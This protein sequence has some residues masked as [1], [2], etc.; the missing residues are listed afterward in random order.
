MPMIRGSGR[1]R[2]ILTAAVVLSLVPQMAWAG[3]SRGS[4]GAAESPSATPSGGAGDDGSLYA[5]VVAYDESKNGSGGSAG[6]VAPAGDW[7][8]PACWFEPKWTPEEFEDEFRRRWDVPHFSGA[9]EAYASDQARYIKGKPYEDF[10]K[11]KSGEGMW[12]DMVRDET[13]A[14]ASDPAAFACSGATFWVD[15]GD[16]PEVENA[17]TPDILA[18]L[19]YS[20]LKVP[21]TKVALAPEVA[22]KVNLPTWAWLDKATFK[23][24]AVTAS[25]D[26]GGLNIQATTT[27]KPVSLKLEPGTKD[28]TTF[29]ASGECAINADGSIGEPYAKGK[30]DEEPSCG[31]TY[32]RSSGGKTFPLQATVTWEIAWTGSGGTGGDLPDGTFGAEQAVTVEEIQSVNR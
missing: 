6:P 26:A 21:G 12:W 13:R 27:A 4:G 24:V 11:E 28:A 25:L 7:K 8:P 3:G 20:R 14:K 18:Q 31:L 29:P 2:A 19:A 32:L 17:I 16:T 10:N 1:V 15:N 23:E 30:A 9:G 5:S 22:T